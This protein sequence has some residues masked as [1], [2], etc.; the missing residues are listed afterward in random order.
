MQ[1]REEETQL[2]N[3]PVSLLLLL[4]AL[5]IVYTKRQQHQHTN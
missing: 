5:P 3:G 4:H 2:N 1:E